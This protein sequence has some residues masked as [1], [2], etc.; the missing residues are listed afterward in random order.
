[1]VNNLISVKM[2]KYIKIRS[3]LLESSCRMCSSYGSLTISWLNQTDLRDTNIQWLERSGISTAISGRSFMHREGFLMWPFVYLFSFN[4]DWGQI[5]ETAFKWLQKNPYRTQTLLEKEDRP[6]CCDLCSDEGI[7]CYNQIPKCLHFS[8]MNL[9]SKS[10]H[11]ETEYFNFWE[12]NCLQ[13]F[14]PTES[15]QWTPQS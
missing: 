5:I 9:P 6:V 10:F 14:Q 8:G 11:Y 12:V 15:T 3:I 2:R 7:Y 1:M 4:T 13:Q